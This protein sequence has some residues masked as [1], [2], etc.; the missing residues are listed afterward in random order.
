VE[1]NAIEKEGIDTP[2]TIIGK[3]I[4]KILVNNNFITREEI[5]ATVEK[6]ESSG[7]VLLGADLVLQAWLDNSFK[8]RLLNDPCTAAKELGIDTSN[9]N[10][11]TILVV[12][13]NT[14]LIH[15]VIVCTLCSCYP[16]ALLGLSPSWYKSRSYR[17][18]M[19]REPRVVLE[20][21]GTKLN[22]NIKI[23]V[24]DSTADCRYLVL[25]QR[26]ENTNHLN[27]EELRALITRDSM[28]G[29]RIISY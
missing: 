5:S 28:V 8:E 1:L 25:P 15:N 23:R 16:V 3:S 14:P 19:V 4:I 7:E 20:E 22:E 18:R 12:V 11:P 21:F 26:P 29:V 9:P 6:L 10:A 2:G 13:E 17:S 24:H 27:K